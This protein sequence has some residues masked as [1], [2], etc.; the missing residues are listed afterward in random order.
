M[1]TGIRHLRLRKIFWTFS[2]LAVVYYDTFRGVGRQRKECSRP[3]TS[4]PLSVETPPGKSQSAAEPPT[5]W[6]TATQ[7]REWSR[8]PRIGQGF[9][10]SGPSALRG[11]QSVRK[12]IWRSRSVGIALRDRGNLPGNCSRK[13]VG[14]GSQK[15]SGKRPADGSRNSREFAGGSSPR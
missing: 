11:I 2:A 9:F 12:S 5:N 7:G 14:V 3:L 6:S 13:P 15:H 1:A 8:F 4:Q 10:P